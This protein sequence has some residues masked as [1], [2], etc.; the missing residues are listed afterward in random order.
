MAVCVCLSDRDGTKM[1]RRINYY[2]AIELGFQFQSYCAEP[3]MGESI[4]KIISHDR[5]EGKV[6]NLQA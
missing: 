6:R 3:R 1:A 4:E 5:N 2:S